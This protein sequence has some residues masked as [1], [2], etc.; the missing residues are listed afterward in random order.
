ML[1]S[2]F[3]PEIS[4]DLIRVK[5][6][7]LAKGEAVLELAGKDVEFDVPLELLPEGAAEGA[8]FT[9]QLARAEVPNN[10]AKQRQMLQAL[11]S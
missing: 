5:K 6:I 4:A 2:D 11:I 3:L 7:K 9:F 8:T 10:D 1:L